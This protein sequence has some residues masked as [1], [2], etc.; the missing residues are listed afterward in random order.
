MYYAVF[1]GEGYL[2]TGYNATNK[3]ELYQDLQS[4]LCDRVEVLEETA[5]ELCASMGWILDECD[6]PFPDV[7]DLI[8]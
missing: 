7:W 1:D 3:E 4:L 6:E 5:D 2:A 8:E